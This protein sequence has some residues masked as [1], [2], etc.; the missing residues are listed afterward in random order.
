MEVRIAP[1]NRPV[2]PPLER[3]GGAQRGEHLVVGHLRHRGP[4][5][6]GRPDRQGA[7]WSRA[8]ARPRVRPLEAPAYICMDF[9]TF[10]CQSCA[11]IHREFGHKISSIMHSDWSSED[12]GLA[13][14]RARRRPSVAHLSLSEEP[15][16]GRGTDCNAHR[17][18]EALRPLFEECTGFHSW[19]PRSTALRV[20]GSP[21]LATHADSQTPGWG[22]VVGEPDF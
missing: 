2:R 19:I 13:C 7:L 1:Q 14:C 17:G 11:D 6:P 4:P 21:N 5:G 3:G 9:K 15:G 16:L 20:Q 18:S 22:E 8:G 12:A 10:V